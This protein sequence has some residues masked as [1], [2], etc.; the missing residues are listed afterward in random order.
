MSEH[1]D[2][3]ARET[4]AKLMDNTERFARRS[5]QEKGGLSA[6]LYFHGDHGT[7]TLVM[8]TM[9]HELNKREFAALAKIACVATGADAS[10]FVSE[11]WMSNAIPGEPPSLPRA[12]IEGKDAKEMVIETAGPLNETL[13]KTAR[14]PRLETDEQIAVLQDRREAVVLMGETLGHGEQRIMPIR[15]AGD[16]SFLGFENT[17]T[18]EGNRFRGEFANFIST[19][20]RDPG[21]RAMARQVLANNGI[22]FD[23]RPA[24][25]KPREERG[26][27]MAQGMS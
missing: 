14:N 2:G 5:M 13:L 26:H 8:K 10:V 9:N 17:Q 22:H 6:R 25:R 7:E 23:Q 12:T 24:E 11:A 4:L 16:G 15:R 27:G 1:N 20:C 3:P 21:Q 18:L 19:E